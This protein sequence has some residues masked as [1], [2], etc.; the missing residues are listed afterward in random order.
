ML[1][2]TQDTEPALCGLPRSGEVYFLIG[3]NSLLAIR[4]NA[5]AKRL[6]D[7]KKPRPEESER[8]FF[9]SAPGGGAP[10]TRGGST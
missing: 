10:N 9:A 5:P 1:D 3:L 6:R 2:A 8:G 7:C 4:P